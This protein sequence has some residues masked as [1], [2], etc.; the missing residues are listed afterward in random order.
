[1][2]P[3]AHR[4]IWRV[5]A[6]IPPG[7]VMSYGQV[8]RCAGLGRVARQVGQ[9]LRAAPAALD[10]PWHRVL[11]AD[12]SIAFPPG[13][14][15]FNQQVRRLRAEGVTVMHGRVTRREAAGR[16]D[17]DRLLWGPGG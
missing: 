12:G 16:P 15:A 3:A 11:R 10:L 2:T 14:R 5:V 8:A 9:A 1:M 17:L 7:R 6:A 4:R 13:S